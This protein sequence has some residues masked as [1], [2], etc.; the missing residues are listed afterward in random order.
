MGSGPRADQGY[1]LALTEI[2]RASRHY[3]VADIGS[4]RGADVMRD[5]PQREASTD[6]CQAASA[7]VGRTASQMGRKLDT[8][9]IRDFLCANLD[10][11][12]WDEV[13]DRCPACGNCTMVCPT[14]FCSTVEASTDL[15]GERAERWRTW[16]S[17]F[18]IAFSYIH[19][20]S[21]RTTSRSRYRQWLM[22]KLATWIDQF[23]SSGCAGC[24]R[25]ITWCPVGIDITEE[26]RA[27]RGLTATGAES[28]DGN[29]R[30]RS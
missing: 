24:G 7:I 20:G 30:K 29:A 12:R 27:M 5:V 3:F 22:R 4:E 19:G 13:A 14:C 23:G 8:R 26:V 28:D 25:C 17:C 18:S 21:I 10:H 1:D 11:P 2:L 16:D 6:E 9:T 15:A